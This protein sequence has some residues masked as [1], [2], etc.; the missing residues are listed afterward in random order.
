MIDELAVVPILHDV[1]LP[2]SYPGGCKGKL[3]L[4]VN[5]VDQNASLRSRGCLGSSVAALVNVCA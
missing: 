5:D 1:A 4:G 2:E 3:E